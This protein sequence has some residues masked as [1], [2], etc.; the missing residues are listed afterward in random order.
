QQLVDAYREVSR[1]SH[2]GVVGLGWSDCIEID[3]YFGEHDGLDAGARGQA[4]LQARADRSATGWPR[5]EVFVGRRTSCVAVV[6]VDFLP[7]RFGWSAAVAFPQ[8]A[9]KGVQAD[10]RNR[11]EHA[12]AAVF[13]DFQVVGK[14]ENVAA[15]REP[16]IHFRGRL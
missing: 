12:C 10:A 14:H 7:A 6:V 13:G 11:V 15:D 9:Q 8:L 5:Q 2:H 1:Y 3:A 4:E 16:K